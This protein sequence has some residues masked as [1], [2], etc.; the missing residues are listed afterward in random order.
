M[1]IGPLRDVQ[2]RSQL[3]DV[4]APLSQMLEGPRTVTVREVEGTARIGA[5]DVERLISNSSG[6]AV[7][8]VYVDRIDADG[9][10]RAVDEDG[11]DPAL[12]KLDPANAVRLG[13]TVDVLGQ[14]QQ[15]AII[16]EL[17]L[18]DGRAQI[19][20]RDV[21]LGDADADPLPV[22]LQRTLQP[23]LHADPRPGI[24]AAAGHA[25]HVA[26]HERRSGD[27]RAHRP[28]RARRRRADALGRTPR[29]SPASRSARLPS[30]PC[31]G[32]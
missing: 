22:A 2:V 29:A 24:A 28:P 1:A 8:K 31:S 20:P 18:A 15:V 27:Q 6:I 4:A 9:L 11:A 32:R 17:Q 16:A 3:R 7:D 26:G 14:E 25:H 30:G 10:E 13:G 21:R 5:P 19:T 12:L 23:D